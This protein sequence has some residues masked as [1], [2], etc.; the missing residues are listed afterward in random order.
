[1]QTCLLRRR[2]TQHSVNQHNKPF[3]R[4]VTLH[5]A[6]AQFLA[7]LHVGNQN[8]VFAMSPEQCIGHFIDLRIGEM[9]PWIAL[10]HLSMSNPLSRF[11]ALDWR[12]LVPALFFLPGG[13]VGAVFVI[14]K[15]DYPVTDLGIDN[16]PG[17]NV[18]DISNLI[19]HVS[20]SP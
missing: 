6:S 8:G 3:P 16:H 13:F 11:P 15:L 12:A 1:M 17:L 20:N 5:I 19:T 18:P 14:V 4:S 2:E 9:L 10:I 7:S